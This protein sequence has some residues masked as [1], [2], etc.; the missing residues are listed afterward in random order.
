M[1]PLDR[2]TSRAM[3]SDAEVLAGLHGL[4]ESPP[5]LPDLLAALALGLLLAVVIGLVLRGCRARPKATSL[6]TKVSRLREMP[7]EDRTVALMRLMQVLTDRM[8]P[9]PEPWLERARLA[10]GRDVQVFETIGPALYPPGKVLDPDPLEQALL[11]IA[12]RVR[13]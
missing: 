12:Q 4:R 7:R 10:F 11:R 1:W 5:D 9:G 13:N 3:Q 8:A 6:E 2:K